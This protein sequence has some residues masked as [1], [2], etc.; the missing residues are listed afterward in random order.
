MHE[1]REQMERDKLMQSNSSYLCAFLVLVFTF[2][3]NGASTANDSASYPS[4]TGIEFIK[5]DNIS[6]ESETLSLSERS[7]QVDYEF[8][9]HAPKEISVSMAFPFPAIDIYHRTSSWGGD[10]K[11]WNFVTDRSCPVHLSIAFLFLIQQ[12]RRFLKK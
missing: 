2:I 3:F 4:S 9:N 1:N 12:K 6:I 8:Y 11:T 7:V 10:P 5:N